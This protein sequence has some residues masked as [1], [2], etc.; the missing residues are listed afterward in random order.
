MLERILRFTAVALIASFFLPGCSSMSHAS[1][2]RRAYQS[3]V[4][5][6]LKNR[7]RQRAKIAKQTHRVPKHAASPDYSVSTGNVDGPQSVVSDGSP[8]Y[9]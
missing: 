5:K 9:Q 8:G 4:K 1:R 2:Q 6:C 7:D 3:Y